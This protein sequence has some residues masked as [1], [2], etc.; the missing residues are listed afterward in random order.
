MRTIFAKLGPFEP[1]F[2]FNMKDE[3]VVE[4]ELFM[5]N[6]KPLEPYAAFNIQMY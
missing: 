1:Y 6:W 5:T 3:I 4:V 2:A